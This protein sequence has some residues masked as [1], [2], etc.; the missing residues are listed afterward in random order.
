M[1]HGDDSAP[2]KV[3]EQITLLRSRDPIVRV[4]AARA[5]GSMGDEAAPAVP[6]LAEGLKDKNAWVRH[7]V[8]RALDS[9]G[10]AT[11]NVLI[12]A[13]KEAEVRWAAADILGGMREK[14]KPALLAL[15]RALKD[16]E[17]ESRMVAAE[18]LGKIGDQAAVAP[19]I[20]AL[21]DENREVRWW[22]AE[23]LGRIG[24][25]AEG[26]GEALE[27]D[28][29]AERRK[30]GVLSY[31][32]TAFHEAG[33]A[34][35]AYALTNG[36]LVAECMLM[37]PKGDVAGRCRVRWPPDPLPCELLMARLAFAVAGSSA[38]WRIGREDDCPEDTDVRAEFQHRFAR[39]HDELDR[40][41]DRVL[42]DNWGL[43]KA[44]ANRLLQSK[45]LDQQQILTI[46][47][48]H[49]SRP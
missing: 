40:M 38:A 10:P 18:A 3:L 35:A 25:D 41:A 45:H 7:A 20:E 23:A 22:A 28:E 11:L 37:L 36:D 15:I 19:L 14:A 29:W 27:D 33:H 44:L 34:V 43:V 46:I 48:E 5:L 31:I 30:G 47:R 26:F 21:K 16:E 8:V 1:P 39:G 49:E 32:G 17:A 4:R 24:E 9:I 2:P 13:L 12:E 42:D 6:P